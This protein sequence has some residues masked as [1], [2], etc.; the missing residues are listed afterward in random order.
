MKKPLL[1]FLLTGSLSISQ[2]SA[3]PVGDVESPLEQVLPSTLATWIEGLTEVYAIYTMGN[4]DPDKLKLAARIGIAGKLQV[5]PC[6]KALHKKLIPEWKRKATH[7][8]FKNLFN[9]LEPSEKLTVGGPLFANLGSYIALLLYSIYKDVCKHV[10]AEA[11]AQANRHSQFDF[12]G[13]K[14]DQYKRL[15][16]YYLLLPVFDMLP[17]YAAEY[18]MCSTAEAW[19]FIAIAETI[20]TLFELDRRSRRYAAE[21]DRLEE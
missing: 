11:L 14:Q 5:Y 16:A 6:T 15:T 1:V 19:T 13:E 2:P 4:T 18:Q 8:K 17:L 12:A 7:E 10:N 20:I 9:Q 21:L 3:A